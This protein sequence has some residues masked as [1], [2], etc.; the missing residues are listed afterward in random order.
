MKAWKKG[1]L[2]G[3]TV[4]SATYYPTVAFAN[5]GGWLTDVGVAETAATP[6]DAETW[7]LA[8]VAALAVGTSTYALANSSA[9]T[10]LAQWGGQVSQDAWNW[11]RTQSASVAGWFTSAPTTYGNTAI[12]LTSDMANAVQAWWDSELQKLGI[13]SAT[14]SPPTLLN[15]PNTYTYNGSTYTLSTN[16]G[17]LY[18]PTFDS[19][20]QSNI[21][22]GNGVYV[23]ETRYHPNGFDYCDSLGSNYPFSVGWGSSGGLYVFPTAVNQ[24]FWYAKPVMNGTQVVVSDTVHTTNNSN[25]WALEG[26]SNFTVNPYTGFVGQ[27]HTDVAFPQNFQPGQTVTVPPIPLT[28]NNDYA[29]PTPVPIPNTSDVGLT[30]DGNTAVDAKTGTVTTVADTAAEGTLTSIYDALVNFFD[31]TK[32][33]NWEPVKM[34]SADFS[35][36]FPFSLP[37][38]IK[39]AVATLGSDASPPSWTVHLKFLNTEYDENIGFPAEWQAYVPAVH[40]LI[41]VLFGV[42]L[43]YATRKLLGGAE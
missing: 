12:T 38:D 41:L 32:P 4:L 31:L 7:G 22:G 6:L 34:V 2:C 25:P 17:T 27:T 11:A 35:K 5:V 29:L 30:A 43:V 39:N 16:T 36:V 10:Y 13:G 28:Q 3:F 9:G 8:A 40:G 20:V 23:L 19:L 1:V 14:S 18:A 26:T 33:I 42:G 24:E 37:W 21:T 15:G